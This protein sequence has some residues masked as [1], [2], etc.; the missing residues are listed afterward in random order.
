MNLGLLQVEQQGT[1]KL[2]LLLQYQVVHLLTVKKKMLL[3]QL[4][5]VGKSTHLEHL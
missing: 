4:Q 3:Q 2:Q 1:I 5:M